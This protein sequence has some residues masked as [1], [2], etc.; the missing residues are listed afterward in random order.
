MCKIN[1]VIARLFTFFGERLDDNKAITQF[2]KAA[3]AG[4]PIHIWGDGGT[5]RS[6]M[7]GKEMAEWLWAILL[8]GKNG[9]AYDVGSDK[10]ITML[11]LAQMVN[12]HFGNYSQIII[13]N[14]QENCTYYMPRDT[15]KTKALL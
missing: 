2:V 10:P 15:S 4:T 9:E 8:R 1:V 7:Y 6:Y 12:Q 3:R 5:V 11:A 13:E 14:R